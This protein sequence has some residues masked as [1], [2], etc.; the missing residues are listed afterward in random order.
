VET[1]VDVEGHVEA[2]AV[3]SREMKEK[4]EHIECVSSTPLSLMRDNRL[5]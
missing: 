5:L 2:L 4:I 3:T 1:A